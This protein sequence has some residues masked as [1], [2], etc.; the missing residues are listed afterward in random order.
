MTGFDYLVVGAGLSGATIARKLAEDNYKVLVIDKR[1]HIGGNTYD[2]EDDKTGIRVSKYGAHIFHTNDEDVWQFVSQYSEW[3]PYEHKVL[4]KVKN[5]YVPVPVNIDTVNKL[6]DPTVTDQK[7]MQIYLDNV[8]YKGEITNSRQSALARV[9]KQLYELIFE[10]YTKKQ[11]DLYPE[12]LDPTV[13]ERIPVRTDFNDRYFNDT[14]EALPKNGYTAFVENILAHPNIDVILQ[15]PYNQD[16]HKNIKTIFTGKIDTYFN[17]RYGSLEYRSLYFK[18]YI[19]NQESYQPTAVVNCPSL[20]YPYTRTIEYKKFYNTKSD[21][22]IVV[23]EYSQAGGE[24]YYPIPNKKNKDKYAL[25][26]QEATKL[27]QQGIYFIGRLAEYKYY[28]M[29]QAI[30]SAL[31]LYERIK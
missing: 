2:Y 11:W 31:N 21:K 25:Y 13:L 9:G 28:N 6:I 20:E 30:K 26:Q 5:Q 15:E 23:E 29:D 1:E 24:P 19:Y 8:Q 7:T 4:A 18:Q 14:Y 16:T 10:N 3:L 22:T 27:E 12:E 17:D